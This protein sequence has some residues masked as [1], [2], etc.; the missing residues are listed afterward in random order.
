MV[1]TEKLKTEFNKRIKT[2]K[3]DNQAKEE[4]FNK[5]MECW[6]YDFQCFYCRKRM[7]LHFENEYSFT[8]DHTIPK[9]KK[10]KDTVE[11]LEFVCRT[12][13]FLKGNRDA[14]NYINNMERL[15]ARKNKREYF[16]AKKFSRKDEQ[17]RDAYKDIF[18]MVNKNDKR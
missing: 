7:D 13:N 12:C 5:F 3:L 14:E 16:K 15:I 8:I 11:N 18:Q 1:K 2:L 6:N 9:A 10:G 17:I 4:L